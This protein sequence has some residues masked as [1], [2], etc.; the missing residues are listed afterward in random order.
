MVV[1]FGVFMGCFSIILYELGLNLGWVYLFM[2]VVIGSAVAPLWNLLTSPK[3]S[4][5]GAVLAAWLGLFFGLFAWYMAAKIESGSI[6]VG[7]LGTNASML[8][9]NLVSILSSAIIHWFYSVFVDPHKDSDFTKIDK[10]IRLVEDDKRGLTDEDKDPNVIQSSEIWV[11]LRAYLLTFVLI[12]VWPVLTIPAGVFSE[13]YFAFWVMIATAR[14]FS[15]AIAITL[16][17]LMES[18][19]TIDQVMNG[20]LQ[21]VL[22]VKVGVDTTESDG[23]GVEE[24]PARRSSIA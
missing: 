23:G 15:A 21:Y 8:S 1:L 14:G 18:S 6:D 3:A 11:T 10:H 16:L 13:S 17:P 24:A 19:D 5:T 2:G 7:T 20:V 4:G 12:V 22:C 9:G